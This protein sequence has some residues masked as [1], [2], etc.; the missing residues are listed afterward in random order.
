M[1]ITWAHM[2]TYCK[3]LVQPGK[4]RWYEARDELMHFA[5]IVLSTCEQMRGLSSVFKSVS[6]D[7]RATGRRGWCAQPA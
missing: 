1:V 4:H 2:I 6:R 5:L 3:T 7:S